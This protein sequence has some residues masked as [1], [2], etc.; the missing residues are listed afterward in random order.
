M[1]A[2]DPTGQHTFNAL[3][4]DDP[5][6]HHHHHNVDHHH[7]HHHHHKHHKKP[8]HKKPH[9]DKHLIAKKVHLVCDGKIIDTLKCPIKV[10]DAIAADVEVVDSAS[11][12][13][14]SNTFHAKNNGGTDSIPQVFI[15]MDLPCSKEPPKG[16]TADVPMANQDATGAT[17]EFDPTE[18]DDS[19]E[20]ELDETE[21]EDSDA[22][23]LA[24]RDDVADTDF[25]AS[26]HGGGHKHRHH[27][28]SRHHRHGKHHNHDKHHHHHKHGHHDKKHR[29]KNKHPWKDLCVA[30]GDFCGSSLYGC[31]FSHKTLYRCS[32]IGD[33]PIVIKVNAEECGGPPPVKKC[34]CPADFV[35][36]VCG[37]ELPEKCNADPTQ[38]YHCP[39]GPLSEFEVLKKC[40]PGTVCVPGK[41]GNDATCGYESCE[42][43]GD[44]EYCSSQFPARC[45]LKKN[46]IY[47]CV[48]GKLTE[49]KSCDDTAQECVA[50]GDGAICGS[51]KCPSDGEICGDTF[52][53]KCRLS[54]TGLYKCK[55]GETPELVKECLPG[56]CS[57]ASRSSI[58]FESE[59]DKDVCID[60]CTC[61]R[62]G[63][64]CGR[65]FSPECGLDVNTLYKCSGP[66]VK[67]EVKEKCENG[68]IVKAGANVCNKKNDCTCPNTDPICGGDLPASCKA[69]SNTIYVCRDGN[70][71]TPE[72]IEIC[73]PG[74]QCQKK[75]SPEGAV[76]G[77]DNCDCTGTGEICSDTF[78]DKC[79]LQKNTI[80]KCTAG[81][82]PEKVKTCEG[83]KSCVSVSD[84][85]VCVNCKCLDDGTVCGKIFPRN[86]NLKATALYTC[87]KG[88]DP[89]LQ[90]DCYPNTCSPSKG[91][92][93]EAAGTN[94]DTCIDKCVCVGTGKVCGSTFHPDCKLR[95]STLYKCE[96]KGT[97]PVELEKCKDGDCIVSN[98]DN[99]CANENKCTCP[100]GFDA[101]CGSELP[102]E[103]Q[104]A[105]KV[106]AGAVYYCPE[107]PGTLPQVKKICPPGHICQ[108]KPA[109][110]GATCGGSTCDCKGKHEV[111]SDTFPEDCKLEKNTIYKCSETG[112]PTKVKTCENG[113]ECITVAD[114]AVCVRDDC[115]CTKDGEVCG[116]IFPSTC[117]LKHTAI[118]T[119]KKGESPVL[120]T[121]CFP[122]RCTASKSS[123]TEAD[124]TFQE[125]HDVCSD[126]CVC[127][128]EG[129][130]CGSSF[131]KKCQLASGS[132]YQ[133]TGKGTKPTLLKECKDGH[134]IVK[135]GDDECAV[136]RDPCLCRDGKDH[137]GFTFPAKCHLDK[138]IVYKCPGGK[139]TKPVPGDKCKDG[140]CTET[141][142]GAQCKDPCKCEDKK[143]VCGSTFPPECK[144]DADTVY[145][146]TRKGADPVPGNKCKPG[147]CM[148]GDPDDNCKP[149]PPVDCNCRDGDDI[150]GSQYDDSCKF[151]K[152]TLY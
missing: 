43:A 64:F 27:H 81:G 146:C 137:C 122:E 7:G 49:V 115:K 90:K 48:G 57:A 77:S 104:A 123:M 102:V 78:P 128:R 145:K 149:P 151:D 105:I 58:V 72:P 138:E 40:P 53:L 63:D 111:C 97:T 76:C 66:G 116:A 108:P 19:E 35:H 70:G 69:D 129:T 39:G 22:I 44:K 9:H 26:N 98:G 4:H 60:G 120:K 126:S 127:E 55:K 134:C 99:K 67:P 2:A 100:A 109:P 86:C 95:G 37:S 10:C 141:A 83:D 30:V 112:T 139:G 18:T 92:V 52:P 21:S 14:S 17:K 8:H 88:E 130:M 46:T 28:H 74:K 147:E 12:D 94:M 131:Q 31:D 150:C 125:T 124:A 59:I 119:C 152:D 24:K 68:C 144:L 93:F 13:A 132:L 42:C 96:G 25:E 3:N 121:D 45:G 84:G 33:R 1:N 106:E 143:D 16:C 148:T 142:D 133:C 23:D 5:K 140:E 6:T 73:P 85:A 20:T 62:E 113:S 135:P 34:P 65:S 38:I 80:Y 103:C 118:Y 82:K 54:A 110:E 89:V 11:V 50:V 101:V 91:A 136:D 75:P 56:Y 117:N 36:A 32:A 114:G 87:K 79:G 41:D 15:K 107:G 51:C 71:G 61:V 29:H 47:K